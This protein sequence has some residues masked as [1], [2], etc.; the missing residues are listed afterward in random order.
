MEN[1]FGSGCFLLLP[2]P[3]YKIALSPNKDFTIAYGE[4]WAFIRIHKTPMITLFILLFQLESKKKKKNYSSFILPWEYTVTEYMQRVLVSFQSV[5][6][7]YPDHT[8]RNWNSEEY[9]VQ[10][11]LS[12]N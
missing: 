8:R 1:G 9:I 6:S 2:P 3:P 11:H 7:Y 10:D 4:A 12:G 5:F